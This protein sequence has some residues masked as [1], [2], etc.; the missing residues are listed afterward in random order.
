MDL[1]LGLERREVLQY[2]I[3][4]TLRMMAT[5]AQGRM[6]PEDDTLKS[7]RRS[8]PADHKCWGCMWAT[9]CGDRFFC[10]LAFTC[11]REKLEVADGT[12]ETDS[13]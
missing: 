8:I 5:Y 12:E 7:D 9:W 4:H 11:I 2:L 6:R 1:Q 13:E 10:P 3:D